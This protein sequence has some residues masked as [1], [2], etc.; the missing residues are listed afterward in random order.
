MN[1]ILTTA[2]KCTYPGVK[3]DCYLITED[4]RV[5][6]LLTDKFLRPKLSTR[7]GYYEVA[8]QADKDYTGKRVYARIH[9]L[10][11]YQF[12]PNPHNYPVVDHLDAKKTN[13]H[14]TN[15]EWV[16]VLENTR[17]ATT[18]GLINGIQRP[19][20]LVVEIC[21]LFESGYTTME[22][23]YHLTPVGTR[24]DDNLSLHIFI[25]NI[26]C[27][28]IWPD[29]TKD[30]TFTEESTARTRKIFRHDPSRKGNWD[31]SIIREICEMLQ[32]GK[33][34]KEILLY[35]QPNANGTKDKQ[36]RKLYCF[37]SNIKRRKIW[38]HITKDY[39]WENDDPNPIED[40]IIYKYFCD[41]MTCG[42]VRR[43][44][45]I[46]KKDKKAYSRLQNCYKKYKRIHEMSAHENITIRE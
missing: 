40:D 41:G 17:R 35:Y 8:L 19:R 6:S 39:I 12:V 27:R 44:T 26:R 15:L 23:F 16:T 11:A 30:Y 20:E 21:E 37:I 7:H 22:V 25:E 5:Y 34:P 38:D 1:D 2:R 29:V 4:G 13:N 45:G 43:M 36:G 24:V 3:K 46:T 14:Y 42:E 28:R 10:V 18:M 32:A 33:T 31:E 9:R